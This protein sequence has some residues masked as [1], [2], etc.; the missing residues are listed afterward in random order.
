MTQQLP[1]SS[2]AGV[3]CPS[4]CSAVTH[5]SV[6][7]GEGRVETVRLGLRRSQLQSKLDWHRVWQ[8]CSKATNPSLPSVPLP[9]GCAPLMSTR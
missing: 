3:P 1:Y 7:A 8:S 2:N 4:L 6:T 5:S 9:M